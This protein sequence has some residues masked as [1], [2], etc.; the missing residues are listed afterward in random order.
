MTTK[1]V[2]PIRP[3]G[4][5]LQRA[6]AEAEAEDDEDTPDGPGPLEKA[7]ARAERTVITVYLKKNGGNLS[8]TARALRIGRR[9]LDLKID[10]L[11][12]REEASQMRAESGAK[13]RRASTDHAG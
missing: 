11:G 13:G 12:L 1:T 9:T 2:S 5:P 10:A 6:T 8:A 3:P 7:I 4:T